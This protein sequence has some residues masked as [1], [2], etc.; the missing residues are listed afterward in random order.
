MKSYT[1]VFFDLDRTLWDFEK[2]SAETLNELY[3]SHCLKKELGIECSDFIQSFKEVNASEWREFRKGKKTK[4]ELRV[5]RF[6][7]TFFKYGS[8]DLA[9]A[10]QLS[11]EYTEICPHKNHL[12]NGAQELLEDLFN[13]CNIHLITNGFSEIQRIKLESSGIGKYFKEVI[14]SDDTPYRKPQ[15]EI[16]YE[17]V[18][19]AKT[20]FN[21]SI[22]IG[23]DWQNDIQGAYRAGMDQVFFNPQNKAILK[24]E[25]STFEIRKL[26]EIKEIIILPD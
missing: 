13:K 18:K 26:I 6:I 21:N 22:M 15:R 8:K 24:N 3:E 16:F 5:N 17:G 11:Y 9:K 1:D 2:N 4:E 12:I 19:R 23:D 7:K 10:R 20:T 14:I 25:S